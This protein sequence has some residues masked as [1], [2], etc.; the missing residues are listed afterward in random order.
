MKLIYTLILLS[1]LPYWSIAQ[2]CG[3]SEVS[4][5]IHFQ[6]D[7]YANESSW[8]LVNGQGQ[9]LASQTE[10]EN[11]TEYRDTLCLPAQECFT[12]TLYDTHSDGLF[13]LGK[14]DLYFNGEL[15]GSIEDFTSSASL[16]FNCSEGQSCNSA[17]PVGLGVHNYDAS[18]SW[19]IFSPDVNGIYGVSTCGGNTCDT[20]IWIYNDCIGLLIADGHEGTSLYSDNS[21]CGIEAA[22]Q[23]VMLA[24]NSYVIRV[25]DFE[26][27]CSED[28]LSIS[29][30]GPIEGC[31]DTLACNF[32]PYATA[33]DGSCVYGSDCPQPDLVMDLGHLRSTLKIK[34]IENN[35][36]C[37]INE[38]CMRGYGLRDVINFTTTIHNIGE[39]DY[40][41]GEPTANPDQFE[42]DECHKH[43]H[44]DGYAEYVLY[45]AY[46]QYIPIGFKNGFCVIDLQ[47][48]ADSMLTYSC[49]YMGISAGCT[50]T[51][52]NN[53][54]CQWIDI[55]DVLDGDYT[56]VTR[57]NWDN[58]P[59][60]LGR[61]ESDTLNNWAQV[62]INISRAS[63]SIELTVID[64][65]DPYHD[66]A[67]N[68][69]GKAE[70][71]CEGTCNGTAIRGD[72]D[73][74]ATLSSLDIN[75]YMNQA[76]QNTPSMP[77]T[78]LNADGIIN[79]YDASLLM[80]CM[81]NGN[82][83]M[84]EDGSTSHDHCRFPAGIYDA[85]SNSGLE[86]HE[87]DEDSREIT[88]SL[89]NPSANII[90]Y[91]LLIEGLD[92]A[93][94]ESIHDEFTPEHMHYS[95]EQGRII[96]IASNGSYI[97]KSNISLPFLKFKYGDVYEEEVCIRIEEIVNHKYEQIAKPDAPACTILQVNT[98]EVSDTEI[99]IYP[100]PMLDY[101]LLIMEEVGNYKLQLF[102]ASGKSV[103][104]DEF[105]DKEYILKRDQLQ[106]GV[107]LLSIASD[108]MIQRSRLIVF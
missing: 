32:N 77:C 41:I 93:F 106:S 31:M 27:V 67:G 42:Y 101:S 47:C 44:Y 91:Q 45:D 38:G 104:Q 15:L 105:N 102:D 28:S 75:L 83:H 5:V 63:G 87:V 99:K 12:F 14:L 54:D 57:V 60:A 58:A 85:T 24:G 89:S 22:T 26:G 37:L 34:Q 88:L 94:V 74:D 39:A 55:T 68:I 69:Y 70:L 25:K 3:P 46:G 66:C 98:Q 49:D 86:I 52:A 18:G 80:D 62:C 53:L 2:D 50:D 9:I 76:L 79:V 73:Q 21:D 10:F 8:E 107:Y 90:G 7:Q 16:Q 48:P 1:T 51:Y 71:D 4:L 35:D 96:V 108:Q 103:L 17:I 65:C 100:N 59:D 56:F 33:D 72:L 20:R 78:D 19:M 64:E 13:A 30:V 11:N 92:I 36:P 95:V 82:S 29:Y 61:Y 81:I 23:G 43:F 40:F 84:H 6:T 97:P